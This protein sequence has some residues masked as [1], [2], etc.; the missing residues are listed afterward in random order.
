VSFKIITTTSVARLCFTVSQHDTRPAKPRLILRP[1]S[2]TVKRARPRPRPTFW[3]RS[4]PKTYGLRPHH[5]PAQPKHSPLPTAVH[6]TPV[7]IGRSGRSALVSIG[8]VTPRRARLVL[9]WATISVRNQP[10]KSPSVD[11]PSFVGAMNTSVNC[12]VNCW[13]GVIHGHASQIVIYLLT[14]Q[15]SVTEMRWASCLCS[16][17]T[18]PDLNLVTP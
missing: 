4:C 17:G 9:G 13:S 12:E 10:P 2:E 5:C 18:L 15:L 16:F 6:L 11:I 7:G 1:T 8:Q 14:A 3:D